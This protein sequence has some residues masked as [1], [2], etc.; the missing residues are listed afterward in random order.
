MDFS[1]DFDA[2]GYWRNLFKTGPV[3]V[4]WRMRCVIAWDATPGG[5]DENGDN[6]TGSQLDAD[7]DLE[8]IDDSTQQVLARSNT[9][10]S[11][12]EMVDVPVTVGNSYTF[13]VT[14]AATY[15]TWTVIGIA[16]AGHP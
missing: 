4:T 9:Y 3:E 16:W 11:S 5:C 2:N 6:C 13:R 8:V 15:N 7:L 14:K 1:S 12:W 10:D